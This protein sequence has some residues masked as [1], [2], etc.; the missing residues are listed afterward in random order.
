MSDNKRARLKQWLESG[1]A[2]LQPLTFPQRELWEAAPVQPADVSNHICCLIDVRGAITQRDCEAAI[3]RVVERQEVLRLSI[4]PGKDQPL[5]MIRLSGE[6]NIRFRELPTAECNPEGIEAAA[7]EIFSRPFD[8]LQGPLYRIEVLRRGVDDYVM[9]LS[10]HHAIADG[11]TLGVFIQDLC[12]AYVQERMGARGTPLPQ[13]PQSYSAWGAAER[14]F[15][16]P[17]ELE[18]RLPFWRSTLEGRRRLWSTREKPMIH[19]G[20][21]QRWVTQIPPELGTAARELART[22]SVT[23]FSTLLAAFQFA[24]SRWADSDDVL[25][26]TPIA[27][28]SKQAT[29]ESMGYYAG[30]VPL[31]GRVDQGI[32]CSEA[33]RGVHQATVD[34]FANAMPFVELVRGLGDSAAAGYNP[35]FEVRFA[36]QNHPIPEVNLS[37]LSAKLH[38]RSTG[39][40][41]FDLGC[42]LTEQGQA[43][44]VVWLFR[45]GLFS[46]G[47]IEELDRMFQTTLASTCRSPESR[48][49]A[50][51]T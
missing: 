8:M 22:Q 40:P 17:A 21:A 50:A 30:I 15:W 48:L 28:R 16:Q 12:V 51:L 33:L 7:E 34:S 10:I 41:R 47:Q 1:E 11:W 39:T 49:A 9:V 6:A 29:R 14:A 45:A 35:I 13:V 23:L 24:L 43:F 38:M 37:G 42:E 3:Q 46:H 20:K 4:L 31:R 5:Q 27:N 18:A 32:P 26:G 44:E 36:L 25:V 2:R 19:P